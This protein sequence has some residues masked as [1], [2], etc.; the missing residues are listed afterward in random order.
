ML[1]PCQAFPFHKVDRL[2]N[3]NMKEKK[4]KRIRDHAVI[5]LNRGSMFAFQ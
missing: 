3:G 1:T 2:T 4:A 5:I